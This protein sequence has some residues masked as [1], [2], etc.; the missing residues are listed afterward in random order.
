[1]PNLPR[2]QLL[3]LAVIVVAVLALGARWLGRSEPAPVGAAPAVERAPAAK[4]KRRDGGGRALV[5]VAGAVARPGVYR[6]PTGARVSD[7]VR[8]AG[9]PTAK[10]DPN[11]VNLAA[12]VADGAQ[13]VIPRRG[14]AVAAGTSAAAAAGPVNINTATLEQLD[15]LDGIGPVTGE[16]II[17]WRQEHGGFRSVEDL[18]QVSGIGPKTLEA[19]RDDVTV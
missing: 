8:R 9:G 7:A 10:G 13:I 6:L 3:A 11:A 12:E 1:M 16:A 5:H 4:P 19:L 15:T 14:A 2:S 17:A 18:G